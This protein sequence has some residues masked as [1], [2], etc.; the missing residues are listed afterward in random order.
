[1][2]NIV[3]LSTD[4]LPYAIEMRRHFH[5]H[6]EPTSR[7]FETIQFICD[8]LAEMG[9]PFVNIPD[10]G[11]LA[12]IEGKGGDEPSAPHVLLRAD[13]DA[14][15][16]DENPE[17]DGGRK[18]CCIS[19][20]PGVAHMCGHDSH[21]AM[22]LAAARILSRLSPDQI[23]GRIYL[24]FERGEEGG[25]CIYYI[26]KYIQSNNIRIG[27][28]F[29]LHVDPS[30]PVGNFRIVDGPSHAGNVNFEVGLTGKGGHGSRPDLSNNPLDCFVAI[31]NQ[32]KDVRT[33]YVAPDEMITCNIGSVQCGHKRNIVPEQLEFKGTARFFNAKTGQIF[34]DKLDAII[35][36]CAAIYN[37]KVEYHVFSGPSL[38]LIND[39]GSADFSREVV[40]ELFGDCLADEERALGSESFSTLAAYYP[41]SMAKLGVGNREF[42]IT[43]DLHNPHFDLVEDGMKYGIAAHV[44]YALKYLERAPKFPFTPFD[45]DADAVLRFTNR[46]VP[47]RYDK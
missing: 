20:N 35:K 6:P 42:G 19:E 16:M 27:S 12:T 26:M 2:I 13:C 41:S 25:N 5:R 29:A 10:G 22:L 28:C 21:M 31:M 33:K 24:L 39:K 36:S 17:N 32:L 45:G 37:C 34:K 15:T 4:S 23:K 9:I 14:L 3:K 38:S 40:K 43:A 30:L 44:G 7:E 11:V 46:P 47:P 8:Q 18:R 1:M